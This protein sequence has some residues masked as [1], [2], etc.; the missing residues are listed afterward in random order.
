MV[1]GS[2]DKTIR[3]STTNNG[4]QVRVFGPLVEPAQTLALRG[5]NQQIAAGLPNGQVQLFTTGDGKD[6]GK[7]QAHAGG[8]GGLAFHPGNN[9]LFSAGADGLLRS[10][11]LPLVAT[12]TLPHPDTVSVAIATADGKR[13][14]SAA[15]DKTIYGWNLAAPQTPERRFSGHMTPVNCSSRPVRTACCD[16]GMPRTARLA[17]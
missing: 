3:H 12:R 17:R 8:V 11:A 4:Q 13:V 5:D 16:S 15:N 10:W 7:I 6:A 2:A 9:A 14:F 1:T